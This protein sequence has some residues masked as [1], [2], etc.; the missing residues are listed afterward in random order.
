[1]SFTA[2]TA[3]NGATAGSGPADLALSILADYFE[4]SPTDLELR[5][6][7]KNGTRILCEK[8]YQSFKWSFISTA[9]QESWEIS[10]QAITEWLE[11]QRSDEAAEL[12]GSN[13]EL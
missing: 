12:Y 11:L 5:R 4:E 2:L 8:Y 13:S 10:R 7:R 9:D 6:G 1:M 3:S